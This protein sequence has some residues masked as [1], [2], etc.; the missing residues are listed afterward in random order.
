MKSGLIGKMFYCSENGNY[1]NTP[2]PGMDMTTM[3]PMV[4][5][6][7]VVPGGILYTSGSSVLYY[8]WPIISLLG[9]VRCVCTTVYVYKWNDTFDLKKY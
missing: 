4:T 5:G 7:N 3:K 9:V 8:T 1:K 2:M 6:A